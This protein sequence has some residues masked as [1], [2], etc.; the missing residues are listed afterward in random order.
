MRIRPGAN[1]SRCAPGRGLA[2]LCIFVFS[3]PLWFIIISF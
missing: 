2:F 3:V 1:A